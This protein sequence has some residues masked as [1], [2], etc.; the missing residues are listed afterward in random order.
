M[1]LENKVEAIITFMNWPGSEGTR[2]FL[3][4]LLVTQ[5]TSVHC[6]EGPIQ[7]MHSRRQDSLG[8]ILEA[9]HHRYP[10]EYPGVHG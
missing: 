8:D 3:Y 1:I 4:C 5:I 7:S 6:G 10:M 2:S 9:A